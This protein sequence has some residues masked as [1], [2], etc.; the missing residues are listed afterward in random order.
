[1]EARVKSMESGSIIHDYFDEDEEEH[2]IATNLWE[3]FD[4]PFRGFITTEVLSRMTVHHLR[5]H[6]NLFPC[7]SRIQ[8]SLHSQTC[9]A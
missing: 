6:G 5:S 7:R 2:K 1:M 3:F 4:R 9:G 8:R